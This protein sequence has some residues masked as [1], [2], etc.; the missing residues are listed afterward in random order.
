MLKVL[1]SINK[2]VLHLDHVFSRNN[3]IAMYRTELMSLTI[4]MKS[5]TLGIIN[6]NKTY[7]YISI[8]LKCWLIAKNQKR[9][10]IDQLCNCFSFISFLLPVNLNEL[11]HIVRSFS[12]DSVLWHRLLW[13]LK[14][15]IEFRKKEATTIS[16]DVTQNILIIS[17]FRVYIFITLTQWVILKWRKQHKEKTK[18]DIS[19]ALV[20]GCYNT[21]ISFSKESRWTTMTRSK[22][23]LLDKAILS[24][25]LTF[26]LFLF[27]RINPHFTFISFFIYMRFGF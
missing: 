25:L 18:V 6:V 15:N 24:F 3:L 11:F 27:K 22:R 16:P 7:I 8:W 13:T 23:A 20:N 14:H 2:D 9:V 26:F 1:K 12:L 5:E 19:E 17:S 10:L 21:N 4:S